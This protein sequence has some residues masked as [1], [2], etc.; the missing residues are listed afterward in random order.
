MFRPSLTFARSYHHDYITAV[1]AQIARSVFARS[2]HHDC[3]TV[4]LAH[5][6]SSANV[7]RDACE[8]VM[9]FIPFW[10]VHADAAITPDEKARINIS[11][12]SVTVAL[13]QMRMEGKRADVDDIIVT[14]PC[15]I[16]SRN[17][18]AG[19]IL[20]QSMKRPSMMVHQEDE[21]IAK[22]Q[23][24]ASKATASASVPKAAS[25]GKSSKGRGKKGGKK[26]NKSS[27]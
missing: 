8:G 3:I 9:V 15:F 24:A 27:R 2:Y 19:E 10:N 7:I 22:K 25:T 14:I 16:N 4:A 26:P 17:L 21:K 13:P 23:K 5:V 12:S 18:L 11:M 20:R 6:A 1:R